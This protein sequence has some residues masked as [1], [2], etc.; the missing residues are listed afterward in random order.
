MGRTKQLVSL[1]A[2]CGDKPLVAAAFDAIAGHCRQMIVVV[3]HEAEAVI[4][5]L[6]PRSFRS[7]A[8]D[9]DA[10]MFESIRVGLTELQKIDEQATALLQP[11][12]HPRVAPDTV[13]ALVNVSTQHHGRAVLPEYLGRGGHPI[14]IPPFIVSQVLANGCPRGLAQFWADHPH[15]CCRLPVN[16]PTVIMD[17]DTPADLAAFAAALRN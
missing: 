14:L 17:I 16:D 5:A 3:G 15:L 12:D 10:P 1:S 7:V 6:A 13:T 4:A 2:A 9:P 8:G 11:A